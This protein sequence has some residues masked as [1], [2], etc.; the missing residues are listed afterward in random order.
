M[1]HEQSLV[2]IITYTCDHTIRHVLKYTR[3]HWRTDKTSLQ[4]NRP[5]NKNYNSVLTFIWHLYLTFSLT[6]KLYNVFLS[7]LPRQYLQTTVHPL[8][9]WLTDWLYPRSVCVCSDQHRIQSIVPLSAKILSP[10]TQK[11]SRKSKNRNPQNPEQFTKSIVYQSIS[12]LS[13]IKQ[14]LFMAFQWVRFNE[15]YFTD[16]TGRRNFAVPLVKCIWWIEDLCTIG[17]WSF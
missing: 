17:R 8:L 1:H 7:S 5:T 2:Y 14:K 6:L 3:T 16:L 10:E 9:R 15:K 4:T 13:N 12:I 11:Y